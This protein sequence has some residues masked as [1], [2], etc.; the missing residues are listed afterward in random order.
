M[1][2][3]TVRCTS[4]V[5][6]IQ[7]NGRLQ[8]L[9]ANATVRNSARQSQSAPDN[10]QE[11]STVAPDSL[12]PQEDNDANGQLLPNPNGWVT[13]RHTGQCPVAHQTVRCAHRQQPSPTAIWWLRAINTPQPPQLQTTQA[14]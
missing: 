2:H 7:R 9:T 3:R 13:W 14:F 4:G 11:L 6:A 8:R 1:C 12:V 5:T 10:E